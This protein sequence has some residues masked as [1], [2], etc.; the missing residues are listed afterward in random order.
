MTWLILAIF[1]GRIQHYASY[2]RRG[3]WNGMLTVKKTL[4]K[5]IQAPMVYRVL[6]PLLVRPLLKRG[7][8]LENAYEFARVGLLWV[9]LLVTADYWGWQ[10]T[11]LW[12]LL[13]MSAQIYD[14]WCYTGEMIG[15][16]T[17]L[18]GNPYLAILGT[19][20][21][22]MSRETVLINGFV[23]FLA[24]KDFAG[25]AVVQ[26]C[27][28]AVYLAVRSMQGEHKLYCN[29]WM[30]KENIRQ[31][32]QK[33]V[34]PSIFH[35]PY[36]NLIIIVLAL[37]GAFLMGDIGWTVPVLLAATLTMGK[38]NEYRLQIPLMPFVAVAL[39]WLL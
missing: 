19:I 34:E 1:G 29:R 33:P 16:T 18:M 36:M 15:I 26:L 25:A 17:A 13:A 38:I 9:A 10:I 31:L 14:T 11:I 22:G 12:L 20:P 2:P 30:I 6:L 32:T 3:V 28:F 24:T 39:I 4:S 37:L 23:Y 8:S 5:N 35:A 21:H 7:W 27:A